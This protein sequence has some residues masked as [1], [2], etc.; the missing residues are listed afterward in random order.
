MHLFVVVT[1]LDDADAGWVIL[2]P[3]FVYFVIFIYFWGK[4]LK[5]ILAFF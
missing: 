2:E 4:S 3:N 1:L 5:I